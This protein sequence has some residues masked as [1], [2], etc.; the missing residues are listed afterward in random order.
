MYVG[1]LLKKIV[2]AIVCEVFDYGVGCRFFL[3]LSDRR[4]KVKTSWSDLG[5]SLWSVS[6]VNEVTPFTWRF[7]M[8]TGFAAFDKG[9]GSTHWGI[10]T[11]CGAVSIRSHSSR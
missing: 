1:V 8:N 2:G 9:V 6:V 5:Y 4:H 11:F 3:R 10:R 7:G